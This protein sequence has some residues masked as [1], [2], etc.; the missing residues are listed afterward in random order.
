MQL[1]NDQMYRKSGFMSS[2][3]RIEYENTLYPVINQGKGGKTSLMDLID[4]IKDDRPLFLTPFFPISHGIGM[5]DL[6]WHSPSG[7]PKGPL[8]LW[9]NNS[10]AG[11]L[12]GSYR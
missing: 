7:Y 5:L 8:Q 11:V 2:P 9:A 6:L 3:T 1:Y 10:D 12:T 4:I